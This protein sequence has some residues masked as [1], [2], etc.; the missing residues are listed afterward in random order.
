MGGRKVLIVDLN[1]F[2][3]YPTIS[4][5]LLAAIGRR[6]GDEV[7][8]FSPLFVGFQGVA[9]EK[10][11]KP[12]SLLRDRLSYWSSQ[13]SNTAVRS[14]R[15]WLANRSKP[16][17]ARHATLVASHF[18]RE[19]D[20]FKPDVVLVSA[21][22]MYYDACVLM[23]HECEKRRIPMLLGGPYFA[24]PSVRE[25]WINVPGLS[26][27]VGGE[28][29]HRLPE[30][31]SML[32]AGADVS[33][34]DGIFTC[35]QSTNKSGNAA[36]SDSAS[37]IVRGTL[38]KPLANLDQLPHPDFSDFPWSKYP[39][40]IVPMITGRGCGWGAC[41]FCSDVT[42]TAGRTFRSHGV[43]YIRD[44]IAYH[45]KRH[46]SKLFVFTDLKLNSNPAMWRGV[47]EH[48]QT[49]APDA[50]WVCALHVGRQD[51]SLDEATLRSAKAAG[52]ARVTTGLESGSQ[53]V[54]DS[55]AKGTDLSNTSKF[56]HNASRAGLSVRTT[57]IIGYPGETADDV[58]ASAK[59]VEQH[60]EQIDR[61]A[62]NR[63]AVMRGT[64]I[65]K[66]IEE[67]PEKFKGLVDLTI[68]N[69]MASVSHRYAPATESAYATAASRLWKAVHEVN[70]KPLRG[71]AGA[72]E[73]VM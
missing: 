3:R 32:K 51:E 19:L 34:V 54:L 71:S 38:A 11:E 8:V 40:R 47:I 45:C 16:E 4:V 62:L 58:I 13:T 20:E 42:S 27:L 5:G 7:R 26:G 65:D 60:C 2:A 61:I 44:Q 36:A 23:G 22:L 56:L 64:R 52:L 12:W 33:A 48:M 69:R 31:V 50:S 72:F 14:A 73:G 55:M 59:F 49:Q 18:Q 6:A 63:F 67:H 24:T 46:E 15:A 30:I 17:L 21:Y 28:V 9:R 70:R 1:N 39:N 53:R 68:N 10:P 25:A 35:G 41:L 66:Q 43:E 29:E 37:G 57:M